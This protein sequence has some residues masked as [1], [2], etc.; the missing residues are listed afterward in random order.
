MERQYLPPGSRS[1]ARMANIGRKA[2][3]E[4]AR[5]AKADKPKR[6]EPPHR[7]QDSGADR[8][9]FAPRAPVGRHLRS[10]CAA[11]MLSGRVGRP[12]PSRQVN[13][14][15]SVTPRSVRLYCACLE[16]WLHG[17]QSQSPS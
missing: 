4:T 16:S 1:F 11:R 6:Y 7:I 8:R 12:M 10:R 3:R 2:H 9:T 17:Y 13:F 15:L 14:A 5:G